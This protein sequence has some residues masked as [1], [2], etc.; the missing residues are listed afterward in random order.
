MKQCSFLV[1][2]RG[3][4]CVPKTEYYNRKEIVFAAQRNFKAFI[5]VKTCLEPQYL[6]TNTQGTSLI[7]VRETLERSHR[8]LKTNPNTLYKEQTSKII[9]TRTSSIHCSV[10]QSP[11]V[12]FAACVTVS[13]G[14]DPDLRGG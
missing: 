2:T 3:K 1:F 6:N 7:S 11:T 9:D 14:H 4:I 5:E 12:V 8:S 10:T 13:K